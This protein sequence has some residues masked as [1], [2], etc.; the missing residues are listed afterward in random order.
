MLYSVA[1]SGAAGAGAGGAGF[2]LVALA[3]TFFFGGA[4]FAATRLPV[5]ADVRFGAA[6][7]AFRTAGALVFVGAFAF[8]DGFAFTDAFVLA[9]GFAFAGALAFRAVGAFAFALAAA[10]LAFW[11]L[12]LTSSRMAVSAAPAMAARWPSGT[13]SSAAKKA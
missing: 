11:R 4:A 13:A 1:A 9:D 7:A 3:T 2:R 12:A 10:S 6:A 8:A 5:A